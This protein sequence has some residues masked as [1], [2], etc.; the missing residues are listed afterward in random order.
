MDVAG[1]HRPRRRRRT[2]CER[3][4]QAL[5][6][7]AQATVELGLL[8]VG[9]G[10]SCPLSRALCEELGVDYVRNSMCLW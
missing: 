4:K 7:S 6:A 3:V 9:L 5:P 1:S 2:K 10:R 8:F